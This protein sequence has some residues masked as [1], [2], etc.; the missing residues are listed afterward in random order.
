MAAPSVPPLQNDSRHE[1]GRQRTL[2]EFLLTGRPTTSAACEVGVQLCEE[3]MGQPESDATFLG[4]NPKNLLLQTTPQGAVRLSLLRNAPVDET[5]AFAAND[6]PAGVNWLSDSPRRI[7]PEVLR[8]KRPDGRSEVY[9]V[10]V[11]LYELLSGLPLHESNESSAYGSW[12]SLIEHNPLI[13]EALVRA[14]DSAL[15]HDPQD[16]LSSLVEL[17]WQL[18]P[19]IPVDSE[20][21]AKAE[22]RLSR[23]SML[24]DEAPQSRSTP[25]MLLRRAPRPRAASE[26]PRG[27]LLSPVFP[28]TPAPPTKL[29][30]S[31]SAPSEEEAL[32]ES[33]TADSWAPEELARNERPTT[34]LI[35]AVVGIAGGA[36]LAWLTAL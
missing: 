16:R 35:V 21:R 27:Q 23:S 34:S 17:M 25:S 32:V 24:D 11:V 2:E 36:L 29:R 33:K 7:A 30:I 14:V 6:T 3:L 22:E 10:G 1:F 28:K 19:Y 13:P 26:L 4:L 31:D 5:G 18:L 15:A 20:I 8:G 12:E 9:T